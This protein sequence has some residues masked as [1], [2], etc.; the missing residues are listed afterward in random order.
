M[1]APT[2]IARQ[3]LKAASS[4]VDRV[5]GRLEGPRLLIYHQVG[6]GNGQEMDVT[7]DHFR[8]QANWMAATDG[9]V[10]LDEVLRTPDDRS[11]RY[12]ITFDD[13][14]EDMYRNGFPILRDLGLP[15]VI[16]LT[17]HP[18]ESRRPLRDDGLSTPVTWEQ[19]EVMMASGLAT[20]G[21]HT[22][23]HPDFRTTGASQIQDEVGRSNEL[24]A[25]RTGT[26]PRHFTYPW[27]YWTEQADSIVRNTYETATVAGCRT[28]MGAPANAIPRL[29]VQLSDGWGFFKARMHGGFRLE[30]AVRRR[31]ARYAGP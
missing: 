5:A 12:V 14:Y 23:T 16:Y 24:I 1:S 6:A 9:V 18:I 30:D 28:S 4:V 19:V 17:S 20:I 15:F 3:S 22:H 25:R 2:T 26:V 29:P 8:R 11:D 27:G 31:L 10:S 13:G 7:V 21:A